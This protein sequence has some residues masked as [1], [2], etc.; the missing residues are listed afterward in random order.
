MGISSSDGRLIR[1]SDEPTTARI[2]FDWQQSLV[3]ALSRSAEL[4]KQKW[5]VKQRELE[6]TAAKNLLL[7]RLDVGGRWR[8]WVSVNN[9]LTKTTKLI[10]S[11]A[12]LRTSSGSNI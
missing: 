8:F 4:R 10:R 11:L 9:S 3:E 1:P 7:P 12:R 2:S 6:L 5:R